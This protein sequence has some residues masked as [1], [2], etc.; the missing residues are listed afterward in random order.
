MVERTDFGKKVMKRLV[1]IGQNQRWLIDEIN[2]RLGTKIDSSYFCHLMSGKKSSKRI[3]SEIR[4]I[5]EM[6]E[7]T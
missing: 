6:E 5:L 1:D 2:E 4:K 7:A 3:E